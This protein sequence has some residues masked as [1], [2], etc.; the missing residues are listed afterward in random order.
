[1]ASRSASVWQLDGDWIFSIGTVPSL[2]FHGVLGNPSLEFYLHR[3]SVKFQSALHR[4][5]PRAQWVAP[6]RGKTEIVLNPNRIVCA[7]EWR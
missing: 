6:G 2:N 3:T 5:C 1:M 4:E 7:K